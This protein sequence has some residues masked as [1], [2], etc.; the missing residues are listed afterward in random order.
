MTL[1]P[2]KPVAGP[3]PPLGPAPAA[4]AEYPASPVAI[5]WAPIA[6][7]YRPNIRAA[8]DHPKSGMA[9]FEHRR[10]SA[11]GFYPSQRGG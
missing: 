5:E 3:V 7:L 8:S 4:P 2:G 1:T 11:A 9:R 10:A 6:P